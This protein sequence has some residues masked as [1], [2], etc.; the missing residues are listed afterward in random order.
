MDEAQELVSRKNQSC[1]VE[2]PSCGKTRK[3][4]VQ[5]TL[6][7]TVESDVKL[8]YC[9]HCDFRGSENKKKKVEVEP[10]TGMKDIQE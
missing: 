5:K 3:K 2:C 10:M 9:H 6:S 1:R 8:Y 7:I 4:K